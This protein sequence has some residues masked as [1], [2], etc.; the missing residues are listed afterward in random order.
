MLV[1]SAGFAAPVWADSCWSPLGCQPEN[2]LS[3]MEAAAKMPTE[4]GVKT[5]KENCD[6]RFAAEVEAKRKV[7]MSIAYAEGEAYWRGWVGLVDSADLT[8]SD[9]VRKMGAPYL[10]VGPYACTTRKKQLTAGPKD[11]CFV[12]LWADR[13]QGHFERY[14][15]A[16]V[17]NDRT[18]RIWARWPDSAAIN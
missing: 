8:L 7:Q 14:F 17:L 9:V 15:K 5:A 18:E 2:H 13:R 12:Y 3:C 6:V 4:I 11:G 16:E 1:L 10:T